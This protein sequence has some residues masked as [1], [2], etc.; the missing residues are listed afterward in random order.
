MSDSDDTDVLLLI[1]PDFFAVDSSDSEDSLSNHRDWF[2]GLSYVS[3]SSRVDDLINQV[4]D[5]E[6]RI[7]LIESKENLHS[8]KYLSNHSHFNQAFDCAVSVDSTK[9]HNLGRSDLALRFYSMS[10]SGYRIGGGSTDSGS[11]QCH[12]QGA[13]IKVQNHLSLPSSPNP[14][15]EPSY[16]RNRNV[17]AFPAKRAIFLD[18][19]SPQNVYTMS[20]SSD[21]H[22]SSARS[23][24]SDVYNSDRIGNGILRYEWQDIGFLGEIDEF[25]EAIYL[26]I[27][28]S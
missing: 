8:E 17:A 6:E 14:S 18:T 12:L 20:N 5:L 22:E 9:F 27:I 23:V 25:L 19:V 7:N 3:S 13:P 28:V 24:R 11:I 10:S 2:E 4:N 16:F 21:P 15:V 1:P 26:L